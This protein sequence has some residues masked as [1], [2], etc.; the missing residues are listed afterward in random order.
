MSFTV[1]SMTADDRHEVAEL[2]YISINHWYQTHGCPPI[3]TGGPASCNIFFD[4]YEALDPDCGLVAEHNETGKLMASCFYHPR[5]YHVSLGIMTAH[6]NHFGSGAGKAIL[7][8]IIDY[9]NDQQKPLRLTQSAINVDSFSL[10][11]K[12][13]FVPRHAYQDMFLEIP[14]TGFEPEP[15]GLE[16]VRDATLDD[17]SAMSELEYKISRITREKDYRYLIEN[18]DGLW[19]MSVAVCPETNQLSGFLGSCHHPA[20]NLIGPGVAINDDV[21]T[22]LLAHQLNQHAGKTPVFLLPVESEQ[23]VRTAYS[24]G[25]RNCEMHFCQVYGEFQPFDGVNIPTFMPETG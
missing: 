7:Q 8:A 19:G 17:L 15:D 23:L 5:Q 4:V 12:A 20:T 6:P 11:N 9:S 3:F 22:A 24:W 1:R 16:H 21:A 10:Y 14:E 2:I 25:A 13:G 18:K